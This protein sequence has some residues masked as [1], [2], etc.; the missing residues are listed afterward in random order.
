MYKY[1]TTLHC[2][3]FDVININIPAIYSRGITFEN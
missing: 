3:S 2:T 1:T